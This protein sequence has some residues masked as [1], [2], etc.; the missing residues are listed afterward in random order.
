MNMVA[1]EQFKCPL[2]DKKY[3]SKKSLQNHKYAKHSALKNHNCDVCGKV[4][5]FASIVKL[6][7]QNVHENMGP[8]KF[9]C[10]YCNKVFKT[11]KTQFQD[12]ISSVHFNQKNYKCDICGKDFGIIYLVTNKMYT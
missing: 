7:K 4:F 11:N 10:P 6:H 9:T 3:N 12:H 5:R 8:N 1:P 2:C